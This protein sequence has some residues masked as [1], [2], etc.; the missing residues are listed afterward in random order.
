MTTTPDDPRISCR[1]VLIDD[2]RRILLL[3]HVLEDQDFPSVWVP[4]GGGREQGES[5]EQAAV[6]ELWEETGLRLSVLGPKVWVRRLRFPVSGVVTTFEEHFF[7]GRTNAHEVG[8][9]DNVDEDERLWVLGNK[10]WH[11]SEIEGSTE[12]F[13]PRKLAQLLR[14]I[15]AGIYPATPLVIEDEALNSSRGNM[16]Q[17]PSEAR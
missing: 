2:E 14:P 13:A 5:L 16:K 4:P 10:W 11:L 1:V 9:H 12:V 17:Y 7:V 8:E 3:E 6:R 15:L